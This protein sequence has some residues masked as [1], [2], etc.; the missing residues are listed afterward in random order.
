MARQAQVPGGLGRA[1][2]SGTRSQLRRARAAWPFPAWA[3]DRAR[4][5][6]GEVLP[7]VL[8]CLVCSRCSI[9]TWRLEWGD[10][11][12]VPGA[13]GQGGPSCGHG[14]GCFGRSFMSLPQAEATSPGGP[15][16]TQTPP[17]SLGRC[18]DQVLWE[19]QGCPLRVA[20]ESPRGQSPCAEPGRPRRKGVDKHSAEETAGAST[21]RPGHTWCA[22]RTAR[23][24]RGLSYD[25]AEA[26]HST[27]GSH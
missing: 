9:T 12:C 3:A 6:E 18:R 21:Q 14:S 8:L 13:C 5:R 23:G 27:L 16:G 26:C 11:D 19:P 24:P 10:G 7:C 25:G 2:P 17:P 20:E 15:Q 4:C 22:Q 1:S